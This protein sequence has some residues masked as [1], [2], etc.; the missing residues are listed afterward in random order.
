MSS[1]SDS[2]PSASVDYDLLLSVLDPVWALAAL[3]EDDAPRPPGEMP[4]ILDDEG[5]DIFDRTLSE[6]ERQR[7][8]Y[9]WLDDAQNAAPNSGDP[10]DDDDGP[11]D[12]LPTWLQIEPPPV[13]STSSAT[14]AA[15]ASS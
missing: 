5:V 3:P 2:A 1:I 4:P 7:L 15:P 14:T 11:T 10:A 6:K 13:A 9:T 12:W 8:A